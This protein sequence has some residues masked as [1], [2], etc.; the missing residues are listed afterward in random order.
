MI[1]SDDGELYGIDLPKNVDTPLVN[2]KYPI[3]THKFNIPT[4][5]ALNLK[6]RTKLEGEESSIQNNYSA[7]TNQF[8]IEHDNWRNEKY[9]KIKEYRNIKNPDYYYT[10]NIKDEIQMNIKKKDHD[11]KVLNLMKESF[12]TKQFEKAVDLFDLLLLKKSKDL[13]IQLFEGLDLG[14]DDILELLKNKLKLQNFINNNQMISLNKNYNDNGNNVFNNGNEYETKIGL[15]SKNKM[16]IQN[17]EKEKKNQNNYDHNGNGLQALALKIGDFKSIEDE[18]NCE[19]ETLIEGNNEI[20]R[21]INNEEL[22]SINQKIIKDFSILE[23][24]SV[25]FFI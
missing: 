23:K 14:R 24:K 21:N 6:K 1:G 19:L 15:N 22:N 5:E 16:N 9:C 18:V 3:T 4:T 17:F 20:L 25:I 12:V 7:I 13:A 2:H 8:I 10:D 11:K